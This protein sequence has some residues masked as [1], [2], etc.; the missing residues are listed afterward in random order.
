M[1]M[2][3]TSDTANA[4]AD[5]FPDNYNNVVTTRTLAKI[6][7]DFY[8]QIN[9]FEAEEQPTQGDL[10]D[11]LVTAVDMLDTHC[12]T[13]KYKK[14]V[15]LITDGEQKT[16]TNKTE[17]DSLISNLNSREIR[18]NIITLDFA[19]ELG[20]ESDDENSNDDDQEAVK[21]SVKPETGN[22][23][24]NKEL[25]VN[26]TERLDQAAIFPAHVA[27]EIY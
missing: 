4:L 13:K 1:V 11:G 19:N 18:L 7:Q 14:R 20:Q 5:R 9:N 22:Q 26:I 27:M 15:F 6:D 2:F 17:I 3:G 23:T 16:K 10:I 21:K 8:R 24:K 25:L 12:G